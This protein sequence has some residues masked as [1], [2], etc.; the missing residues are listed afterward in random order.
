MSEALRSFIRGIPRQLPAVLALGLVCQLVQITLLRELLMVFHGNEIAIG[1]ILACWM[2]WVGLG[3]RLGAIVAERTRRAPSLLTWN[4]AAVLALLPATLVV[5]RGLRGFFDVMPGAYLSLWDMAVSCVL[6][7]AP[8]CLLLGAQFVLL[9]RVWREDIRAMDTAGVDRTYVGE[10]TGNIAGGMLF[11]FLLVHYLGSFHTVLL[12]GVVMLAAVLWL[13]WGAAPSK[14]GVRILSALLLM[15]AASFPLLERLDEWA[16]QLQW[17]LFAPAYELVE[18]HHSRHGNI[19]AVRHGDQYSFFQSGHLVFSTA[20]G[21]GMDAGFEEQDAAVFAHFALTQHRQPEDVLLIGGGLRGIVREMNRHALERIDYIEVDEVLTQAAW[22]YLPQTTRDTLA[23]PRVRLLHTDGR[24]FVKTAERNYDMI[25]VD[26]PD[27]ATAV[28][29]RFYTEEFF[30]EAKERLNPGGVLA[31]AVTSTADLRGLAIA[32]R[33]ATIYHTLNRV[34]PRVLP[35][36]ERDLYFFATTDPKQISANPSELQARYIEREVESAAF[37]PWHFEMLLEDSHLRRI[38]WILRNHG[39]TP[40]AHL[41]RP[42]TGPA[43]PGTIAEQ[44]QAEADLPP[45]DERYFIN[46]DFRPIGY[47]YTVMFWNVLTGA[48]HTDLFVAILRVQAWW[49]L[50]AA[51]ACLGLAL[52]LRIVGSFSGTRP[53]MHAAV[54]FAV[55]TTGLSTMALQIALLFSFQNVYGHVYEMIGL[56][57]A[58]FMAGLALGA[59]LTQRYIR[60]KA[61]M[62]LLAGVQALIAAFAALMAVII[63]ASAAVP[64]PRL[65]FL[66]FSLL[67]VAAGLFNGA[68]F[69]L[70]AASSMALHKR[71]EKAGGLV[72]GV[73]LFGGCAGAVLASAVVAPVLGIA[74][75]CLM[76]AVANATAFGIIAISRR[77]YA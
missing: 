62:R 57:V 8:V 15:A 42:S 49:I 22:P 59:W 54:L 65:I 12:A 19:F 29:N 76:A 44:E 73:E 33:N 74:A 20:D 61:D 26:V 1:L 66:L 41:Q 6:V 14:A 39:R 37:S 60:H 9:A 58:L 55:F 21:G 13:I 5:I 75:C 7:M 17:R 3:S 43:F 11:S 10:A 77:H 48:E 36:G 30:R 4:A 51:A 23:D 2:L 35:A 46:S 16:Y 24:L 70:S 28:L 53:D 67:T 38:N 63:P 64:D 47:Y 31:L 72:Y 45:P 34:F 52:V 68:G 25:L 50:P 40:G 18:T 27:P 32:N 71:P 56:I 69:P